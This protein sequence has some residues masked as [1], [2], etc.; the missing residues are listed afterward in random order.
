MLLSLKRSNRLPVM[1]P[2]ELPPEVIA[3]GVTSMAT[4]SWPQIREVIRDPMVGVWGVKRVLNSFFYELC[5][6]RIHESEAE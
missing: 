4:F 2:Q 6:T 5:L 3:R 1:E